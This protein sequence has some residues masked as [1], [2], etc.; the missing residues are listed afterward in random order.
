LIFGLVGLTVTVPEQL[1]EIRCAI[2]VPLEEIC[3]P[4]IQVSTT[5]L[6]CLMYLLLSVLETIKVGGNL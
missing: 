3:R 2:D 5:R 6:F 1:D 4:L